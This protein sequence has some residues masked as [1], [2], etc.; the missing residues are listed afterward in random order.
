[1]R[2]PA[3]A[4]EMSL[5]SFIEAVPDREKTLTV[6]NR[7]EPEPIQ[8]ML[9]ALFD[10]QVVTVEDVAVDAAVENAV[11]V[12]EDGTPIATSPL[13]ALRDAL[14]LVNSDM[15][16]SGAREL[17]EVDTPEA[18][19]RLDEVPF[20]VAGYPDTSKGKLLLIELSR[21]IEAR[22]FR[23]GAGRLHAGF[24]VLDRVDDER[25]TRDVYDL[26]ADTDVDV[27]LYAGAGGDLDDPPDVTLRQRDCEEL[28]TS[29]FVVYR[30][31]DVPRLEAALLA[32]RTTGN[33]WRG[34]WTFDPARVEAIDRYLTTAYA[35]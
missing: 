18:L 32:V 7:T 34:V 16:V 9:S 17:A 21:Y 3:N 10:E 22:A 28:R 27:R 14:L 8:R 12:S 20:E 11:V 33:R 13:S 19:V 30:R 35:G 1:M 23:A 6:V 29:W 4:A 2:R 24:Q 15:Y 5:S 25:G 31:P 26:L